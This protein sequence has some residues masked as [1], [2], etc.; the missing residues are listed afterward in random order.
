[1]RRWGYHNSQWRAVCDAMRPWIHSQ[2]T[3][4]DMH[5][6]N[7]ATC[8]VRGKCSDH[9]SSSSSSS[10][11]RYTLASHWPDPPRTADCAF[12][13]HFLVLQSRQA[14]VIKEASREASQEEGAAGSATAGADAI[15][16]SCCH[17]AYIRPGAADG[18]SAATYEHIFCRKPGAADGPSSSDHA[19]DVSAVSSAAIGAFSSLAHQAGQLAGQLSSRRCANSIGSL[20]R[21]DK[22]VT[23]V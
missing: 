2:R 7:L 9:N 19:L 17:D 22:T 11:F 1:M 5:E 12:G 21:P 3:S 6:W 16:A 4:C 14:Q 23:A 13:L 10:S 8:H 20:H 15:S 18:P